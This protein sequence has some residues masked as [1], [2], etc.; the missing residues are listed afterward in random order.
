MNPKTRRNLARA[1]G[2]LIG[3]G[4]VVGLLVASRPGAADSKSP[5]SARIAI[6]PSGEFEIRPQPPKPF[7]TAA[8]MRP[9]S[10]PTAGGFRMRNQTGKDLAIALKVTANS[11]ALD[12]LLRIRGRIGRRVVAD[13]TL[14]GLRRR[15]LRLQLLSG[16]AARVRLEAWL[17][18]DILS[19]Y[20]GRLVDVTLVPDARAL[21]GR[22]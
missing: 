12:G 16:Q 7:L 11:S 5:A 22:Q 13:T 18:T 2:A 20:A 9:G 4:L 10:G 15:P 19:G 6:V 21:G 3:V 14:E 17:P 8:A 1:A